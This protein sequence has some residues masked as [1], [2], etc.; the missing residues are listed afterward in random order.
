MRVKKK[1]NCITPAIIGNCNFEN[2]AL[3]PS[4]RKKSG[5]VGKQLKRLC[6]LAMNIR[7]FFLCRFYKHP[8]RFSPTLTL[9]FHSDTNGKLLTKLTT[10]GALFISQKADTSFCRRAEKERKINKKSKSK[11]GRTRPPLLHQKSRSVDNI[12]HRALFFKSETKL[13]YLCADRGPIPYLSK[14]NVHTQI[15]ETHHENRTD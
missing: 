7:F 9:T 14:S 13:F 1:N 11:F 12:R 4:V 15:I 10:T 3:S 6:V 5:T 2:V 8:S